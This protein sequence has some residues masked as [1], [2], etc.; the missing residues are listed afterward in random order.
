[1]NNTCFDG[2]LN[3]LEDIKEVRASAKK[4]HSNSP[5]NQL[6]KSR[7]RYKGTL[8]NLN[9]KSSEKG[10][11]MYKI[12]NEIKSNEEKVNLQF[13]TFLD[14]TVT[15]QNY[16]FKEEGKWAKNWI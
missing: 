15:K 13:F 14:K 8:H 3:Q 5:P 4:K 2:K 1:M 6:E 12:R 9:E 10:V 11:S 16:G 7:V